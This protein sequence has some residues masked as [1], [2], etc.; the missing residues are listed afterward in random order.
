MQTAEAKLAP[1]PEAAKPVAPAART[2]SRT[3]KL[4]FNETRELERL[5]GEIEALEAEQADLQQKLLDPNAYRDEPKLAAHW[6]ARIEEIDMG[7]LE[8]LERWETLEKKQ[9]GE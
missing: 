5:P 2:G 4:S 1:K 6:Q 8:K 7:L 3:V 9:R